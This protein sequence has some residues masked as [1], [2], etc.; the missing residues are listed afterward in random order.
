MDPNLSAFKVAKLTLTSVC[1]L[2]AGSSSIFFQ[3]LYWLFAIE[4]ILFLHFALALR[5][6]VIVTPEFR[7]TTFSRKA[8]NLDNRTL[9]L[10]Q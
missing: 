1:S 5:T 8:G 3:V 6:Y 4:E 2:E 10:L 7:I 9:F